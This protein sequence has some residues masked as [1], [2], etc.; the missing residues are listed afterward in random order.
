MCDPA[1]LAI[2]GASVGA[3]SDL[4]GFYGQKQAKSANDTAA[5]M[6]YFDRMSA[7]QAQGVQQ[8]AA[9]SERAVDEA[10]LQAQEGGRIAVTASEFLGSAS[11]ARLRNASAAE[12]SRSSAVEDL[13]SQNARAQRGRDMKGAAVERTAAINKVQKPSAAALALKLTGRG[14]SAAGDYKSMTKGS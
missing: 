5:N 7:L 9:D 10:I 13:N 4:L 8:D 1:T 14:L 12:L 2:A 6:N 3:T 11:Q